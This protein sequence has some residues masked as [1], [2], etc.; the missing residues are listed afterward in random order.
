M[1]FLRI[2]LM[3][4]LL[5]LYQILIQ[6]KMKSVRMHELKQQHMG[7]NLYYVCNDRSKTKL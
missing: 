3:S 2:M 7:I 6:I 1:M 5:G 4:L